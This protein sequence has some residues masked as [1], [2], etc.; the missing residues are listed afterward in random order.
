MLSILDAIVARIR[1]DVPT[2]TCL[3]VITDNARKYQN[4]VVPVVASF[5]CHAHGVTM[6]ALIHLGSTRGTVL[7]DAHFSVAMDNVQQYVQGKGV[8]YAH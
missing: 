4:D 1:L 7:V 6:E 5:I 3:T 2:F 8:M